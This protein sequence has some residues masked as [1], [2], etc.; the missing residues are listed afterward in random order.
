MASGVEHKDVVIAILGAS[1]ALS[2]L[3]LVFLGLVVGAYGGLAGDTPRVVK[4]P[5]RRTGL[6]VIGAFG[7]G[8]ACAVVATIWLVRLDGGEPLYITTAVLFLLQLCSLAF[9]SVW[10]LR[11]LLWD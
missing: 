2:G 6:V 8:I 9:A 5:L 10:T 4:V 7:A 1:A 3:V 11:E